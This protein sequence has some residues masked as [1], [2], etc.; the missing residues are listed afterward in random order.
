MSTSDIVLIIIA[1]ING[2]TAIACSVIGNKKISVIQYSEKNREIIDQGTKRKKARY[3][4]IK[5]ISIIVTIGALLSLSYLNFVEPSISKI[6]ITYPENMAEVSQMEV[7]QGTNQAIR[8]DVNI[9]MVIFSKEVGVYYPQSKPII[10]LSDGTWLKKIYI[11]SEDDTGAAFDILIV[12]ANQN[13]TTIFNEYEVESFKN[14]SWAG[15]QEL[16]DGVKVWDRITVH[17][18]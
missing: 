12:T 9:W 11:G 1:L 13:A 4:F 8:E 2:I 16:P 3:A 17:R 15:F 6:K 14:S 10:P 18:R 7:I 5:V